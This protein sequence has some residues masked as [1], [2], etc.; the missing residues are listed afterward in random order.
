MYLLKC[1]IAISII[2]VFLPAKAEPLPEAWIER[3]QEPKS[4]KIRPAKIITVAKDYLQCSP[5]EQ[6]HPVLF[7]QVSILSRAHYLDDFTDIAK[8]LRELSD[9]NE[10][11]AS[12]LLSIMLEEGNLGRLIVIELLY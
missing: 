5:P 4:S 9:A 11:T 2:S 12:L 1:L 10:Q 8:K 6:T 7:D 3:Y